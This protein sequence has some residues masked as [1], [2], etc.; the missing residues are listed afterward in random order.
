MLEAKVNGVIIEAENMT[1]I[2]RLGSRIANKMTHSIDYMFVTT[3]DFK[4]LAFARINR[5]C[6]NGTI[7]RGTWI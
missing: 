4:E 2:K 3:E 1:E 6:P 7:V 5:K